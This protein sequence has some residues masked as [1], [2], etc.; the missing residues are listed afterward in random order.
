MVWLR[1]FLSAEVVIL[2]IIS[3]WLAG[4]GANAG[5]LL[6]STAISIGGILWTSFMYEVNFTKAHNPLD[7]ESD[8]WN[9]V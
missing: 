3:L 1:R 9:L 7:L 4:S 6:V 8:R 5:I 2:V